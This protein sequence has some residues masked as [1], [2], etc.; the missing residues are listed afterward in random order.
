MKKIILAASILG[1]AACSQPEEAAPVEEEVA[2]AAP[3]GI[4]GG[5]LAGSYSTVDA[6][7]QSAIWELAEDGT[8]TLTAEGVD[9]VT[10]TYTNTSGD[11]GDTFCA[12]PEGDD[13]G[14][15]CWAISPPG[16]DGSWTATAEDGSV[17]TVNR[18]NAAAE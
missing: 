7:G 17:L 10:G 8:F 1:L 18:A 11:D 13:A 2:E 6:D 4:D 3:L 9:P 14:E 15:T 12:D 5:P 16:E